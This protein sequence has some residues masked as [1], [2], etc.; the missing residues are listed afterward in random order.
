MKVFLYIQGQFTKANSS[1][2]GSNAFVIP[3]DWVLGSSEVV[4]FNAKTSQEITDQLLLKLKNNNISQN[5]NAKILIDIESPKKPD[6]FYDYKTSAGDTAFNTFIAAFKLRIDIVRQILPKARIGI[7]G[8]ATNSGP[9]PPNMDLTNQLIGLQAAGDLGCFDNVDDLYAVCYP[10]LGPDDTQNYIVYSVLSA[11]ESFNGGKSLTDS[12]GNNK[13]V[14][15]LLGHRIYNGS[16]ANNNEIIDI[17]QAS[18]IHGSVEASV[19]GYWASSVD[20]ND[21]LWNWLNEVLQ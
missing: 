6:E 7:Y 15:P 10:N 16:S 21:T 12:N 2:F 4:T 3:S 1:L 11:L 14:I 13:N 5:T 19:M 20:D 17:F 18:A 9:Q 8:F